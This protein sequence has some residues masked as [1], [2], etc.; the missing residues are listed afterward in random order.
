[1]LNNVHIANFGLM[2]G[3]L[4]LRASRRRY[5]SG[6]TPRRSSEERGCNVVMDGDTLGKVEYF[7]YLSKDGGAMAS[8]IDMYIGWLEEIQ[9]LFQI[10]HE[11]GL[12]LRRKGIFVPGMRRK[13]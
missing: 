1:M 13:C 9:S 10:L 12:S 3:V 7:C 11:R 2:K 8:V 5:C 4:E 6:K